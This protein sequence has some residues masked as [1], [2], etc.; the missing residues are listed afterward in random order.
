MSGFNFELVT[1]YRNGSSVLLLCNTSRSMTEWFLQT[2][3]NLSFRILAS[4]YWWSSSHHLWFFLSHV[5]SL[6]NETNTNLKF[7]SLLLDKLKRRHT[8]KKLHTHFDP[9]P[10]YLLIRFFK[11]TFLCFLKLQADSV[12]KDYASKLP[13]MEG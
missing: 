4:D 5:A 9:P 1:G 7:C 2:G 8:K 13:Y 3:Q 12:N 6:R 11:A 10:K